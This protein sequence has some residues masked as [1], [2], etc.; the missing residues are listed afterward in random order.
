MVFSIL[1]QFLREETVQQNPHCHVKRE[2]PQPR[3]GVS[4][5]GSIFKIVPPDPTYPALEGRGTCR[6]TLKVQKQSK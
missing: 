4:R 5:K 2:I 3:A 6:S 1:L